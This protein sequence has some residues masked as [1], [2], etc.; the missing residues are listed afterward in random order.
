MG[1][2]IMPWILKYRIKLT[3]PNTNNSFI[4]GFINAGYF[5]L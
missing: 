2:D 4:L 1:F 3:I 5:A